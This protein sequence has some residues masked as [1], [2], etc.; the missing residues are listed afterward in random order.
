MKLAVIVLGHS[1]AGKSSTWYELFGRRIYSG[2]KQLT[3]GDVRHSVFVKNTSPEESGKEISILILLRNTSFEENG[4]EI[5]KYISSLDGLPLTIFCSV[6]YVD[7]G[8]KTL[9]W[10]RDNGYYLYIQW[11]N[12]GYKDEKE[13]EDTLAIEELYGKY[14]EFHKVSGKEVTTRTQA[15]RD[16]L[17]LK[18]RP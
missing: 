4:L 9:D 12:P 11:L 1:N 13:Y 3:L 18:L 14:G 7:R 6:Q 10:F 5:S 17:L 15:I 16:F 2:I 8:L